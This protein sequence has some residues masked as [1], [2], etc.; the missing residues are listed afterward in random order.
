MRKKYSMYYMMLVFWLP[1]D[2]YT[3]I[4][5]KNNQFQISRYYSVELMLTIVSSDYLL[6]S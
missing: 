5:D 1:N 6:S 3:K 4:S 2:Y